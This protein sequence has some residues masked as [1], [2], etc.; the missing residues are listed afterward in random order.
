MFFDRTNGKLLAANQYGK[1]V[2]WAT[3]IDLKTGRPIDTP[4]TTMIQA[5]PKK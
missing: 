1:K 4:M 2:N 3:G 5:R